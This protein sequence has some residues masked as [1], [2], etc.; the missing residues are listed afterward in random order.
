M[1]NQD[2]PIVANPLQLMTSTDAQKIV[3]NQAFAYP[4]AGPIA[5]IDR[6]LFNNGNS[7]G[8]T[9]AQGGIWNLT[10]GWGGDANADIA[11]APPV[12]IYLTASYSATGGARQITISVALHYTATQSDTDKLSVFL[13]ED[14]IITAQL[15]P[16]G[17][18]DTFYRHDHVMRAAVSNALGDIISVPSFVAG[19][20]AILNY[21]YTIPPTDAIWNPA[22]MNVIAFVHQYQHSNKVLQAQQIQLFPHH[23]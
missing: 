16:D 5:M 10:A 18:V 21:S 17:S 1:F 15:M 11:N 19:R 3:G 14:S 2:A 7:Y 20:V 22:N 4:D 13:T 9:L 12:N 23:N 6:N 8:T